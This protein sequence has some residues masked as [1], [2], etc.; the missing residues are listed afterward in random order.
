MGR[1][2]MSTFGFVLTVLG[3]V[4]ISSA[5]TLG[6]LHCVKPWQGD[7]ARAETKAEQLAST[8]GPVVLRWDTP[9]LHEWR[10]SDGELVGSYTTTLYDYTD[11]AAQLAELKTFEDEMSTLAHWLVTDPEMRGHLIRH[12]MTSGQLGRIAARFEAEP[13]MEAF[14]AYHAK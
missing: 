7:I 2:S 13:E 8:G 1:I 4:A 3:V 14:L 10:D 5:I 11:D 9:V 6:T 12:G